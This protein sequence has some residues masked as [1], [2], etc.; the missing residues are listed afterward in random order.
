MRWIKQIVNF[1]RLLLGLL[2]RIWGRFAG[3]IGW[4]NTRLLL[5][6]IFYL[7]FA[8]VGLFLRLFRRDILEVRIQKEVGSYWKKRLPKTYELSQYEKQF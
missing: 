4:F 3:I 6:I 5:I 7:I 1:A 2:F 8:P